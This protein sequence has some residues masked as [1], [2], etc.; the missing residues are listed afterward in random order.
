MFQP[1]VR[2]QETATQKYVEQSCLQVSLA[3]RWSLNRWCP[4]IG[5]TEMWEN[6][7][8]PWLWNVMKTIMPFKLPQIVVKICMLSH[9]KW[10][11]FNKQRPHNCSLNKSHLWHI[12]ANKDMENPPLTRISLISKAP[13]TDDRIAGAQGHLPP[14]WWKAGKDQ[15]PSGSLTCVYIYMYLFNERLSDRWFTY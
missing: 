10:P 8:I 2:P 6:H 15:L 12:L 14:K 11:H 1:H 4:E 9:N 13:N 7:S 5:L 3:L